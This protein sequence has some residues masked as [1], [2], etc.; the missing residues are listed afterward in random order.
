MPPCVQEMTQTR[1]KNDLSQASEDTQEK[2]LFLQPV[3]EFKSDVCLSP[4]GSLAVKT[5][6]VYD[7]EENDNITIS[8]DAQIQTDVSVPTFTCKTTSGHFRIL[9]QMVRGHE[10]SESQHPDFPDGFTVTEM[11]SKI[12]KSE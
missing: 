6:T 9:F 10:I 12:T 8:W 7:A 3:S 2:R 5:T 1:V 11:L 4:A